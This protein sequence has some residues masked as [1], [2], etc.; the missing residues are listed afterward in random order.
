MI[1]FENW[2]DGFVATVEGI[3]ILRHSSSSPSIFLGQLKEGR[4]KEIWRGLGAAR[5]INEGPE[6]TVLDFGH[7]CTIRLSYHE[8]VLHIR[9][10]VS[11]S[12]QGAFRMRFGA[13]PGEM[14]FG[15]G[16][17]IPYNLKKSKLTLS[18]GNENGK[19]RRDPSV[20]SSRGTWIHVDSDGST[21]WN[22]RSAITEL[23]C[24]LAPREIALGFGKTLAGGLELLTRYKAGTRKRLPA[25]LQACPLVEEEGTGLRLEA[26]DDE[27]EAH[28]IAKDE[29]K[30][31]LL[32]SSTTM[33]YRP[34]EGFRSVSDLTSILLSLAFS[35]YGHVVMPDALE[36]AAFSPLFVSKDHAEGQGKALSRRRA[37]SAHIYSMLK[38]YRD[39]CSDEWVKKGIPALA[40]PALM[41][42][43]EP[44]LLKLNDQYMFGPD[45]IVAPSQEGIRQPRRLFLPDDEWIHL[46]T[47][48]HY[49]G[50]TTV[51]H[52]PEGRP[53][54]F[55]RSR[56]SFAA[57]FNALRIMAT[58]L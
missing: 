51:V 10:C 45:L 43:A 54:I 6:L 7:D 11:G 5:L 46:W 33:I 9:P 39:H 40:H 42:P 38:S 12:R 17:S 47:S 14:L 21:D 25:W 35:G 2:S 29:W 41:Y 52:A 4:S 26:S 57:L 44:G 16:P 13:H 18:A 22:F 31:I 34:P 30:N 1:S 15:C 37:A 36:L 28:R 50:G 3:R 53:A 19:P 27:G 24:S 48:R 49:H 23:S 20:L 8:R 32:T 58:R 56:S 55:Y